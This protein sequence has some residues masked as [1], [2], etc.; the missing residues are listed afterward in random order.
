MKTHPAAEKFPM[1]AADELAALTR[2]I[3]ANGQLEPIVTSGGLIID[4]R[5]R[6]KAC[7]IAGIEPKFQERSFADEL[8]ILHYIISANIQR[9]HLTDSQRAMLSEDL[10]EPLAEAA[11]IRQQNGLKQ[12]QDHRGDRSITTVANSGKVDAQLAKLVNVGEATVRRAHAVA[13]KAPEL[14][15]EVREGKL[16]VN[17]AYDAIKPKGETPRRINQPLINAETLSMSAQEKLQIAI[18]QEMKRLQQEFHQEVQKEVATALNDTI[19]PEYNKNYELY[20]RIIK[21][22]EGIMPSETYRLI[23]SCVHPDR[24]QDQELKEKYTKAFHALKQYEPLLCKEKDK[25]LPATAFPRSFAEMMK[26]K[27]E[28]KAK[29][30][31]QSNNVAARG[32]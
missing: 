7:E 29:R 11:A 14:A 9:R 23:L 21:A 20:Q 10:R 8:D 27:A 2:D 30:R 3:S 24:V 19:L 12:N 1:M 15:R 5:N 13:K 28:M 22:H 17:A 25:P 31:R 4:G 32:I 18:R 26:R 6:L 16:S